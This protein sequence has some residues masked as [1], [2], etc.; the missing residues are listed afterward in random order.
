VRG[1][2]SGEP[3]CAVR[4][5]PYGLSYSPW[6]ASPLIF[7]SSS[8]WTFSLAPGEVSLLFPRA[9][10]PEQLDLDISVDPGKYPLGAGLCDIFLEPA[11]KSPDANDARQKRKNAVYPFLILFYD[12]KQRNAA[13]IGRPKF[14]SNPI[15]GAGQL[16]N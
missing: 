3:G 5:I 1:I 15:P 4:E 6:A 14:S 13:Q 9:H 11:R 12:L 8:T 16:N 7:W 2:R 10:F